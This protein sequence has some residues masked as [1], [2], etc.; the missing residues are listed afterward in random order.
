MTRRPSTGFLIYLQ[1]ALIYG[2]SKKQRTE[3]S[4]F[5]SVFMAIKYATEFVPGLRYKLRAMGIPVEGC[6]YI[7][8][9]NQSVLVNTT[10]LHS[11][12]KK[13]SNSVACHHCQERSA[14]DVWRTMYINTYD[15]V[16]DLLTNNLPAGVKIKNSAS[17]CCIILLLKIW[18]HQQLILYL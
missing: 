6:V 11:Q 15:N 8:G 16:S 17:S 3:T 1:R 10:M 5:G 18:V 9:N 4:S 13:R 14:L 12:L 7:Y 2:T